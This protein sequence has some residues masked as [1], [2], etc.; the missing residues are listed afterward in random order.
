MD[1][2]QY[3]LKF[4]TKDITKAGKL[5]KRYGVVVIEDVFTPEECN[6]IMTY[7]TTDIQKLSSNKIDISTLKTTKKTWTDDKL[8]P[9]TRKGLHQRGYSY[10][11]WSVRQD[12]RVNNIFKELYTYIRDYEVDE[13]V[14]SIDAINIRPPIE[15]FCDDKT[16]DW[17]HL[18]QTRTDN[19]YSCI[20]GQVVLTNTSAGFVCSPKSH[21][22]FVNIID[23]YVPE[24]KSKEQ[25][26]KFNKNDYNDIKSMVEDDAK[27]RWQIPIIV[28]KG[29]MILWLSSTVHS[30]KLA[31]YD[32]V[33]EKENTCKCKDSI[34]ANL[35]DF[36][37]ND[38][39][40]YW[41]GVIYVCQRP[42][43]EVTKRNMTTLQNSYDNNRTTNHWGNRM[44]STVPFPYD[45]KKHSEKM[46]RWIKDP[47]LIFEEGDVEKPKLTE[48]GKSL[49]GM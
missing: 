46:Q 28:E 43:S 1:S 48:L 44:F 41:R 2:K 42:K 24:N 16:A 23:K 10:L 33:I 38:R 34:L 30:A 8:F 39:W 18:D 3:Q 5:L 11:G 29:S 32:Q 19:I 26:F 6:D 15:P 21:K 22:V 9:Q 17:A 7:I 40:R 47:E 4:T 12:P 31:D 14:T 27:G 25:F 49:L 13:L 36:D 37:K 20:Q 45:V 35:K